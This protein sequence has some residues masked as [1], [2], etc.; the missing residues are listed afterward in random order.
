VARYELADALARS[1]ERAEA[2]DLL[3]GLVTERPDHPEADLARA[4]LEALRGAPVELDLTQHMRRADRFYDERRYDEAI[5]ELDLAGRPSARPELRRWLHL[6][7]MALFDRRNRWERAAEVL[8]ESARSG[9]PHA[10]DDQFHAARSLSRADRDPEAILAYRRFATEHPEHDKAAEATYLAAWLEIRHGIRGGERNMQAFLRLPAARAVPHLLREASWQ[11]AFSTYRSGRHTRAARLLMEYASMSDDPLVRARGLYWR[12]R[13]YQ[14]AGDNRRAL[15]AYRD[16][17][18]IEPLHWYAL[19]A[20]QRIVEL[21]E[22]PGPPFPE[23]SE[24][25]EAPTSPPLTL[26]E[27][28]RFYA[29]L[30]LRNDALEAL[31]SQEAEI[32]RQRQGADGLHAL[33]RL[34]EELDEPSRLRRLGVGQRLLRQRA[35]PGPRDLWQW[36]AAFP[37]PWPSRVETA[38]SAVELTPAHLYAIMWQESGF[39]PD[40][41]SYADAIGLMQLLPS[42]ADRVA[43]NAGI[44]VTRDML[45]DPAMNIRLGAAYVGGLADRFGIPLAFSAFNGG[46]H[47]VQQWL[48]ARGETE[49]DLFVEEIPYEQTRNYTRRVTTHL[50]HYV[51]LENPARGWPLD[52][53]RTVAPQPTQ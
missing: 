12:G 31:E 25:G 13:A 51:Y 14:G 4:A 7:G 45:F 34:F 47:R 11:L 28:V 19:L 53:P 48:E 33:V 44:E 36:N 26:P 40:A 38:A 2:D 3:I 24:A 32:R 43:R 39:D 49:L 8:A 52:L 46:G 27:E 23:P 6:Y 42:T 22:D 29:D 30:G 21:G 50:A 20:R 35:A 37:R 17:L 9:G 16:A 41:V 5:A 18:Y 10:Q 1:G 15:G